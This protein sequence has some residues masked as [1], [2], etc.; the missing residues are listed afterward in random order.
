M[1]IMRDLKRLFDPQGLLNP[2]K[3]FPEQPADDRFLDKQPGWGVKREG[4]IR[5]R[6]ELGA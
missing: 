4:A 2:H 6:S 3:V 5:D 1:G